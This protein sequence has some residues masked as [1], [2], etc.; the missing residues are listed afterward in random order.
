LR[1]YNLETAVLPALT[2]IVAAKEKDGGDYYSVTAG[3]VPALAHATALSGPCRRYCRAI[4]ESCSCNQTRT[5]GQMLSALQAG[6]A[7]DRY[8]PLLPPAAQ[9]QLFSGLADTPLCDLYAD[10]TD[11]GF[12]GHCPAA[13]TLQTSQCAWCADDDS[14]PTFVQ[15]YLADSLLNGLFGWL[16]GPEVGPC[17]LTQ[18]NPR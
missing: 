6:G 3:L 4:T 11:P 5:F 13:G 17:R 18:W 15:E 8:L 9:T 2:K 12:T 10:E 14:V 16:V 7:A 1:R